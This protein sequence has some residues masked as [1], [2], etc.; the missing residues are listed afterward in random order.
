M[1]SAAGS[2]SNDTS[3]TKDNFV[4]LFSGAPHDYREWR[5]RITLYMTKMKITKREAEGVLNLM[6]SLTGTA[7]KIVE[8]FPLEEVEKPE[9]FNKILKLLD[10]AFE[11]DNRVQLP[12]DI[13]RYFS[14]FQRTSGQTLLDYCTM[15]DE[16]Y[17]RLADHKVTLPGQVQG[18]H[19][20]R[21]AGLTKEQKQ[22][23]LTQAPTLEK[24]KVQEALF[25][26]MGQD[27]KTVAGHHH[28]GG[29]RGKGRGYMAYYENDEPYDQ[30]TYDEEYY[31]N[32]DDQYDGN[33]EYYDSP[34]HHSAYEEPSGDFDDDAAYYGDE[35]VP[36]E[37]EEQA[38][39]YDTAFAAY[40]DARKRFN[41]I[42]LARGY[43][44]IVAL[45][46]AGSQLSPGLSPSSSSPASPSRGKGKGKSPKG[47]GK[48]GR[49]TIK[50]PP[51]GPGKGADPRGRAQAMST[52]CLRCGHTQLPSA[53]RQSEEAGRPD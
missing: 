34:S 35:T 3:V 41:D 8:S 16:L 21:R 19:L 38:E 10:K 45:T 36:G 27:Y 46:E 32:E 2:S 7:W 13:D 53:Q 9:A 37:P 12:G 11:Y 23:V 51:Q 49:T 15:H 4:P 50:Y 6:T 52:T 39:E 26:V 29:H 5:K 30:G 47:K 22:L 17:N 48:G 25:L 18:W 20:L 1:S 43:L 14:N 44:P 24:S 28:K 33:S 40:L 31:E 42:K